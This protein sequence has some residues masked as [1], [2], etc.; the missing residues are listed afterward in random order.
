MMPVDSKNVSGTLGGDSD[1][2]MCRIKIVII[3]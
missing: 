3:P 1:T 2:L